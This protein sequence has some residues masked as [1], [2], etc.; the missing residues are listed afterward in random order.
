[1]KTQPGNEP[2]KILLAS[3]KSF[4]PSSPVQKESS[5]FVPLARKEAPP[6]IE[7]AENSP[8]LE[9]P[10][11][12]QKKTSKENDKPTIASPD[13]SI[14][15]WR[16]SDFLNKAGDSVGITIDYAKFCIEKGDLAKAQT[17]LDRALEMISSGHEAHRILEIQILRCLVALYKADIR[18]FGSILMKI[19][20]QLSKQTLQSFLD[21]YNKVQNTE[22]AVDVARIVGGVAMGASHYLVAR[23]ILSEVVAAAPNDSFALRLLA[24]AQI[25]CREYEEAEK[26]FCRIVQL[27]PQ[28]AEA[29]FN[30]ARFYITGKFD[31]EKA[32]AYCQAALR[33]NPSDERTQ[34]L[35][36]VL[37]YFRENSSENNAK[38]RKL[39]PQLKDSNLKGILMRTIQCS[40]APA[41][42]S[43][44][45][46]QKLA[47]EL[48]L[49]GTPRAT[50]K[51]LVRLGEEYLAR[52]SYFA[53]LKCFIES[54]NLAEI[55]RVYLAMA[56]N[57]TAAG[58]EKGAAIAAGFGMN[59]LNEELRKNPNSSKAHLY[60][61]IYY[62]ER[63]DQIGAR[64]HVEAGLEA[65]S[66]PETHR[67]LV[68]LK[69]QLG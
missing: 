5:G 39:L 25:E 2:A 32:K 24:Q 14:Q 46:R 67:R 30:L 49:P 56:S 15:G 62:F 61:A 17:N 47:E 65:P 60:L 29:N 11:I 9:N 36:L 28:D 21:L 63:K 26:S 52:G 57:L 55:G 69:E 42:D 44:A 6:Q 45:A 13:P 4:S 18:E 43:L 50:S 20:S 3:F 7:I 40:E 35:D 54:R 68:A 12:L 38:M 53:A 27:N 1:V 34:T 23:R 19:R 66:T 8:R 51:G 58:D 31:V 64:N 59:A 16:V 37:N 41:K 33:L 10:E 22:N 48:A